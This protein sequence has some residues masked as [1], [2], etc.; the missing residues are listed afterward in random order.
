MYLD[1][2]EQEK[3]EDINETLVNNI[4]LRISLKSSLAWK[5]YKEAEATLATDEQLDVIISHLKM[6]I[7]YLKESIIGYIVDTEA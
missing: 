6:N 1:Y 3:D 4:V 2:H 5:T 7:T